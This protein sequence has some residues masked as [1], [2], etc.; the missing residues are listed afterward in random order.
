[1][2]FQKLSPRLDNIG[3]TASTL[4]AIH[5]AVVPLIFTSLPLIGL[6]FLA[7]AWVEWGMI[8]FALAIGVYSIGLSYR[9]HHRI[10]PLLML[11]TGFGLILAG[12]AFSVFVKEWLVVPAGGLLIASAHFVNYRYTGACNHHYKVY[13]LKKVE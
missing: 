12:H 5:C 11:I 10:L 9:T 13:K 1:M 6:G 2:N 7:D 8:V 4:C 3:I